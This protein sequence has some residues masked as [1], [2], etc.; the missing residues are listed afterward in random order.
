MNEIMP[1]LYESLIEPQLEP[2]MSEVFTY[3]WIPL[4]LLAAFCGLI[5]VGIVLLVT[6]LRK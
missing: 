1:I 5:A 2:I 6:S 4:F 3:F